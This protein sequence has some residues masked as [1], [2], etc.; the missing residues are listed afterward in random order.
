MVNFRLWKGDFD[1]AHFELESTEAAIE[2]AKKIADNPAHYPD[3][4]GWSITDKDGYWIIEEG[5]KII[6]IRI[7]TN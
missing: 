4:D 6:P 1:V 2:L 5:E 3:C 7:N